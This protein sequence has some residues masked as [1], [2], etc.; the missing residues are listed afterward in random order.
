[1]TR[2]FARLL[3][4]D[5]RGRI[6]LVPA[7][8]QAKPAAPKA[9]APKVGTTV[10]NMPAT[11]LE[12][13]QGRRAVRGADRERFGLQPGARGRHDAEPALRQRQ[14]AAERRVLLARALHRCG[15]RVVEVVWRAQVHEEVERRG[16]AADPGEPEH[17]LLSESRDPHLGARAW[18]RDVSRVRRVRRSRRWRRRAGRCHLEGRAGVERRRQSDHDVEHE[19]RRLGVASF[20][21][22]TTGRSCRSTPRATRARRP[23]SSRSCGSGPARRRRRSPT[24]C[25]GV[26]IYD[27]LFQWAP[28]PGAA[29]Y[30]MEVNTTSGFATGSKLFSAT[31][32]A[33]SYAPTATLPNNT[34]YWRVRGLD[35]Q[36]Q[37]GPWNNGPTFD[38][39]YDQTVVPG[40]PN[41]TVLNSKLQ[42]IAPGGNVNEPVVTWSTV[43]GARTLRAA[44]LAAAARPRS[45][46]LR[47]RPGRRSPRPAARGTR[48]SSTRRTS[49]SRAE[50]HCRPATARCSS[51]PSPTA[52]S[53]ARR[54]PGRMPR[55]PSTSAASRLQ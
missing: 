18:R 29:S 21:A 32:T 50:A 31:T 43:P 15:Q 40:P 2:L 48:S 14:D 24:W 5:A 46:T 55:R 20:R 36:G 34:Y 11:D 28:I 38:K 3:A 22:R 41:L 19:P 49:A 30:E 7:V 10:Q 17:D 45:T 12:R 44:D 27:P 1:M 23:R 37:A 9:T 39:T 35:S 51:A 25:P 26:E 47:T 16:G 4:L 33:T 6:L 42:P 8:A 53:K 54:L 13:G 52:R